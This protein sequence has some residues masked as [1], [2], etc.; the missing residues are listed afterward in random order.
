MPIRFLRLALGCLIAASLFSAEPPKLRLG[1]TVVPKS[2]SVTLRLVPD[3][4]EFSGRLDIPVEVRQPLQVIWLNATELS[5][6]EASLTAGGQRL[7]AKVEAGGADFVGL[8]FAQPVPKGPAELHLAYR[9]KIP[10]KSELGVFQ[11]KDGADWYVFTH[12]EPLGARRA[13]PCFDEPSFKVPWQITLEVKQEHMALSNA[14]PA[15]ETLLP[16]GFKRVRFARTKPL[17]SYLVALAAGPFDAV[18][19]GRAGKKRTPLRIITPRGRA[20]EATFAAQATPQILGRLEAYFG[21]PYPYEKLDSIA[22]PQRGGAMEHPGLVTYATNFLLSAQEEGASPQHINYTM[23]CAHELAHMWAGGLVSI[24]W[25]DDNWLKEGLA[26]WMQYRLLE[27][28]KQEWPLEEWALDTA[29]SAKSTDGSP[30]APP[31]R[32]PIKD[33]GDI[34]PASATAYN[35]AYNK[36]GALFRMFESWVGRE[37]FRK[38]ICSYLRRFAHGNASADD[39]LRTIGEAT[40]KEAQKALATFLDQPGIPLLTVGLRCDPGAPPTL[41]LEQ[42]R[43]MP[44]G[45]GQPAAQIWHLP[46][47][48]AYE[49]DGRRARE[50]ILLTEA[51][52]EWQLRGA[53]AC[54]AWVNANDRAE[55][56]YRVRYEGD[57]LAR[58]VK[59]GSPQLS[60]AERISTLAD[61][62][63]PEALKLAPAFAGDPSPLVAARTVGIARELN[64]PEELRANF[65]RFVRRTFLER[66][67]ALGWTPKA[68]EDEATTELRFSLAALVAE[69]GGESSLV[70][71]A[72]Q[73]ARRWLTDRTAIHPRMVSLVLATAS[74]FGDREL[75]D[76]VLEAAKTPKDDREQR[77]ALRALGSFRDPELARRA[78]SLVLGKGSDAWSTLFGLQAGFSTNPAARRLAFEFVRQHYAE[79]LP[80]IGCRDESCQRASFLPYMAQALC[81]EE[82]L[83]EVEGFFKE[84]AAKVPGGTRYLNEILDRIRG[85]SEA[86]KK[87]D[88]GVAE[89]LRQ[90]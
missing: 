65:G 63:R 67:V 2:Y 49:V 87:P 41:L 53:K 16:G 24:A 34:R 9:G 14:P 86:R 80:A 5:I 27:D 40:G 44:Q 73:L 39:F 57:L 54:P 8:S 42:R 33:T 19:A 68:G 13:F 11:V 23:A 36:S 25:W 85:C 69:E 1:N 35:I 45:A 31:V 51:R 3:Q 10:R 59:D 28:W 17:P 30:T 81:S 32:Q 61:L 46:A 37:P 64:V 4:D 90:Y 52:Q 66:A 55:G 78:L 88:P 58:L 43:H 21:I 12:F 70:D 18:D 48:V 75:F 83:A 82:D 60:P 7:P 6:S 77:A 29:L 84:R 79:L 15:V 26:R 72:R 20:R 74:A 89:F 38:G 47:C 76:G 22:V 71:E 50:C 62:P 56:Y